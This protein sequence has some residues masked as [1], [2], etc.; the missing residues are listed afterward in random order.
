MSPPIV[1]GSAFNEQAVAPRTLAVFL[2][3][4]VQPLADGARARNR[5]LSFAFLATFWAR[6]LTGVR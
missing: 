4:S 5:I 2:S 3:C 1:S 6:E